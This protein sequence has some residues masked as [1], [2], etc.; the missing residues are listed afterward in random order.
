MVET[1]CK[2]GGFNQR[3]LN[4]LVPLLGKRHTQHLVSRASLVSTESAIA[5]SFLDRLKAS[6]VS[7][8]QCPGQRGDRANAGNSSQPLQSL[9]QQRVPLQRTHKSVVQLLPA[10]DHLPA[11]LQ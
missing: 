5:D 2:L 10:L 9:R 7:D 3:A 8:L 11:Q 6:E 4:V 1:D